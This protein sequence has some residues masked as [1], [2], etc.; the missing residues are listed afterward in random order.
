M[1]GKRSLNQSMSAMTIPQQLH[2][3]FSNFKLHHYPNW[4]AVAVYS[5]SHHTAEA[6]AP[7][8][9]SKVE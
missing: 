7:G 1:N 4:A 6:F 5:E 3:W 9:A 8:T 2:S